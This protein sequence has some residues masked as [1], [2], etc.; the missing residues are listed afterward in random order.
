M[1]LTGNT[2]PLSPEIT[3]RVIGNESLHQRDAVFVKKREVI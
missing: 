2:E 3:T 1:W